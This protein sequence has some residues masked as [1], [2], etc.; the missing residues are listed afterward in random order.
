MCPKQALESIVNTLQNSN[1]LVVDGLNSHAEGQK[2][3]TCLENK[4]IIKKAYQPKP[5]LE[6]LVIFLIIGI[7]HLNIDIDNTSYDIKTK[8]LQTPTVPKS[9]SLASQAYL[10]FT[11]VP[12]ILWA[13]PTQSV[14]THMHVHTPFIHRHIWLPTQHSQS[15]LISSAAFL[16][17]QSN[18]WSQRQGGTHTTLA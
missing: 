9:I 11:R 16:G 8:L 6:H 14:H 2:E 12:Q 4:M 5:R 1:F 15:S 10:N 18:K 13:H 3:K 7:A 17:P